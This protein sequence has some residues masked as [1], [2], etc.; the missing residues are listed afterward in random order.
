MTPFRRHILGS[1]GGVQA[2]EEGGYAEG[3]DMRDMAG[4]SDG[5]GGTELKN[6]GGNGMAAPAS[7]VYRTIDNAAFAITG[8]EAVYDPPETRSP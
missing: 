8:W 4:G 3:R 7:F 1:R 5:G 2:A 6:T